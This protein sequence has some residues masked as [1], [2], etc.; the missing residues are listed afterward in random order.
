M[1]ND[2]HVLDEL[3]A[4]LDGEAEDPARIESH[5]R[6]CPTCAQRYRELRAVT[7][8]VR[9]LNAPEV[10]PEFVKLVVARVREESSMRRRAPWQRLQTWLAALRMPQVL[11][12]AGAFC[13]VIIG[14]ALYYLAGP[15]AT[16]APVTRVAE[17][18]TVVMETVPQQTVVDALAESGVDV[19]Q[20]A[21]VFGA[22]DPEGYGAFDFADDNVDDDF[23]ATLDAGWAPSNDD[24][25]GSIESLSQEQQ[26]AVKQLLQNGGNLRAV[27][28]G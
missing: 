18:P 10:S 23:A 4:L 25:F 6:A 28:E 8:Q 9:R 26:A 21:E 17:S 11:V 14:V 13:G 15:A 5:V 20:L 2:M 12:P 7:T 19:V 16:T 3:S 1:K 22:N 27:S 24:V